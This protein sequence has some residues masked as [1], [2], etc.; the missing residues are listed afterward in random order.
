MSQQLF[1]GGK[2]SNG[3]RQSRVQFK[4]SFIHPLGM[5]RKH[6]GF[7][8]RFEYLNSQTTSLSSRRNENAQQLGAKLQRLPR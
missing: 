4:R 7:P 2:K 3:V 5:N 6:E 1:R 8:E